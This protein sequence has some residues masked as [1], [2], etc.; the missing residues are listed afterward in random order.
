MSDVIMDSVN[1]TESEAIDSL[2]RFLGNESY[3]DRFQSVCKTAIK[4]LEKQMP[5]KI[6]RDIKQ[7]EDNRIYHYCPFCNRQLIRMSMYCPD[8][9][10]A[11]DWND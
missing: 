7:D 10:Q 6:I 4:A 11:I 3:T 8:C 1:V 2:T 9:G 5:K